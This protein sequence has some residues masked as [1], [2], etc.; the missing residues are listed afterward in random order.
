M[1]SKCRLHSFPK[2]PREIPIMYMDGGM[3]PVSS[4]WVDNILCLVKLHGLVFTANCMFRL[5]Q[6]PAHRGVSVLKNEVDDA[7]S[8]GTFSVSETS[9][10]QGKML[11]R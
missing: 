2:L 5:A 7:G 3:K 10:P 8:A 1:D 11:I 6:G 9:K 4:G